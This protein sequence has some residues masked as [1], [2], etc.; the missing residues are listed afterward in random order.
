VDIGN[1]NIAVMPLPTPNN[2]PFH[3]SW[4]AQT[5]FF[6]LNFLLRKAISIR[7]LALEKNLGL[8]TSE[9]WKDVLY[10]YSELN[11]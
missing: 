2:M 4:M 10:Y 7:I 9:F 8:N 1:E 5:S 11:I 3:Y 6:F